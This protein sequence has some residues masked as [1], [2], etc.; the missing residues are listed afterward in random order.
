MVPAEDPDKMIRTKGTDKKKAI[1]VSEGQYN[2][3]VCQDKYFV[4]DAGGRINKI[5]RRCMYVSVFCCRRFLSINVDGF[6]TFGFSGLT[7]V[8]LAIVS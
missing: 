8:N 4:W 2:W 3:P 7:K 6:Y 5:I 1:A